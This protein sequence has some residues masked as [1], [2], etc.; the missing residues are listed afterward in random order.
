MPQHTIPEM[1]AT[2]TDHRIGIYRK[3]APFEQ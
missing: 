2:F 1:H 3:G